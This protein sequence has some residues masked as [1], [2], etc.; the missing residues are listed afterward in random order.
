VQL[1]VFV[2]LVFSGFRHSDIPN[3]RI[4]MLVTGTV[5]R[6]LEPVQGR[7]SQGY[8][9]VHDGNRKYTAVYRLLVCRS[10]RQP[11]GIDGVAPVCPTRAAERFSAALK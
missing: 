9:D 2:C 8:N 10:R 5:P 6:R 7:S 3:L 11:A 4:N 1:C